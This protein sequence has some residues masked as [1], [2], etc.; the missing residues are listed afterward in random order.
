[1]NPKPYKAV[2]FDM[3]GTLIRGQCW[4]ILHDHFKVDWEKTQEYIGEYA[5]GRLS[6]KELVRKEIKLW[7]KDG[8][9][10]HI[11]E[12]DDTLKRYTLA[13]NARE[14][15]TQL[16][17]AGLT[18]A[19]VSYGL[20][21]LAQRV[22]NELGVTH[23]Y[24]NTLET[25]PNGYITGNQFN[26]VEL[27]RKNKIVREMSQELETPLSKFVGVGDTK[28]DLSMFEG[29]GLKVAF[30]TKDKELTEAADVVVRSDDLGEILNFILSR[31]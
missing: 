9:L 6:F 29:V 30:N 7:E 25:D 21:I 14:T 4:K 28:Y 11:K 8:K 2:I 31:S 26:R 13:K 5:Q 17:Q 3:D 22:G 15:T 16:R 23:V 12:I 1:M 27:G 10:P 20:D 18:L 19:L 24:A